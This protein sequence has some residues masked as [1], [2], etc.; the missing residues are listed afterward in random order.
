MWILRIEVFENDFFD[1]FRFDRSKKNDQ[2]FTSL[3]MTQGAED[4]LNLNFQAHPYGSCF[5]EP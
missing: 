1:W 2:P 4:R 5:F 3:G